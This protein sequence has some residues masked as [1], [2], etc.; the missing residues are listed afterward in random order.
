MSLTPGPDATTIADFGSGDGSADVSKPVGIFDVP[1]FLS[2]SFTGRTSYLNWLSDNLQTPT[3]VGT[4][5]CDHISLQKVGIYGLPG[6]GKTQIAL[7]YAWLCR[8]HYSAVFFVS[9]AD[10][11]TLNLDFERIVSVLNLPEKSRTEQGVKVAAA[12]E[13]LENSRCND[14]RGWLLIVDNIDDQVAHLVRG[15][16]PREHSMPRGSIIL[17]TRNQRTVEKVGGV[18][19]RRCIEIGTMDEKEAVELLLRASGEFGAGASTQEIQCVAK[20]IGYLPLAINQAATYMRVHNG[21]LEY[22]LK[23]FRKAK[24]EVTLTSTFTVMNIRD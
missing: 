6:V 15:F 22:F 21:D 13:W 5:A 14:G 11:T 23:L 18:D 3:E 12:R 20:E 8:M 9:A 16:L 7:K 24:D 17:T 1:D 4:N 10:I 19:A 2:P